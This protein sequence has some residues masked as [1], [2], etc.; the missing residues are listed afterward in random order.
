VLSM[1]E[2]EELVYIPLSS[3]LSGSCQT[4]YML[5]I[6]YDG[7]VCVVDNKCMVFNKNKGKIK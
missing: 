7:K 2:Y 5:A 6:D 4:A 3:G 1:D